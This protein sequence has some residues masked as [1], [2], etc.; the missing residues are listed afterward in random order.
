MKTQ[1]IARVLLLSGLS[2]FGNAAMASHELA[3]ALI[4]A[5][6]GAVIGNSIDR[7]EGAIV[8]GIFGAILGASIADNDR[9]SVGGRHYSEP[10]YAQPVYVQPGYG[11]RNYRPEPVVVYQAPRVRYISTPVYVDHRHGYHDRDDRRDQRWDSG[12]G[13]RHDGRDGLDGRRG[14]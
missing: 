6:T 2:V 3:G 11:Y 5:G 12:R 7:H 13:S 14:G 9:Y 1:L 4:G 10:V 8:G